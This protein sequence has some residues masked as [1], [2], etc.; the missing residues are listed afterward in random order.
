MNTLEYRARLEMML[1]EITKELQSIGIH[2]PENPSDWIAVP[3]DLDVE[4][5]DENL[6]ADAVEEWNERNALVATLEP[7][8]NNIT[9]ALDRINK[10][11]F[12]TC[13]ICNAPI[14]EKRLEANPVSRTC[15]EHMDEIVPSNI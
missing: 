8:Y 5:P 13:E 4:E 14:E 9:A 15:I 1:E 11:I 6:S 3:E 7:Q 2:N 10:G 12:G